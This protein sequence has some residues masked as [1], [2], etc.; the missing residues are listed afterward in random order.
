MMLIPSQGFKRQQLSDPSC[1]SYLTMVGCMA[2]VRRYFE[3]ALNNDKLLADYFLKE[4]QKVYAVERLIKEENK[5]E[6]EVLALQNEESRPVLNALKN[7]LKEK[8]ISTTPSTPIG[9]AIAYALARWEKLTVYLDH[10]FLE[11]DNN[12]V[13]NAIRPT[14]LGRKNF[15]FSGSHEGAQRS[16]MIYS[17]LG[18]CKMNN[19]NPKEGL[20]NILLRL[21]DTKT[22]ELI[23]LL[24][25]N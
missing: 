13:E 16:A 23:N 3:K 4:I 20:P 12:L 18:S 22:S 25:S 10:A 17:F 14:V 1:G 8:I 11:I 7:W 9:K 24:P 15:M 2:H 19:V 21:P 5:T 6:Q